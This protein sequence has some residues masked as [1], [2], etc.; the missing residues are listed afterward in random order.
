MEKG[1]ATSYKGI[2]R[3][4]D[5]RLLVRVR[6]IDPRTGKPKDAARILPKG[7][8]PK[9]DG[10]P[11]QDLLLAALSHTGP[12]ASSMRFSEYAEQLVENR[13]DAGTMASP[14]TVWKARY[15]NKEKLFPVWGDFFLT[16][17]KRSDVEA[18]LGTLGKLVR[19]GK[20]TPETV[21]TWWRQFKMIM[22]NAAVTFDIKDPTLK[23]TGV[24]PAL[25]ETYTD[26][27][28]NSL[29]PQEL[30]AFFDA[31][32]N[33]ERE[34][35]AM[36][37]LGTLTGRRPCELR[38]LRRQGPNADIDWQTGVLLIRRSQTLGEALNRTKT[39]KRVRLFLPE[40]LVQVLQT[41]V[42]GLIGKRAESDLLFP[43]RWTRTIETAKGYQTNSVLKK[44]LE[45]IC[46]H[47]GIK[48]HLTPRFMRRTYQDL[49]RAAGVSGLVQKSMSGHATET[50]VEH[51]S[52]V[53]ATEGHEALVKMSAIAGLKEAARL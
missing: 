5:G 31:A 45:R 37:V 39:G 29:L 8:D 6:G 50:M 48:K 28:P 42:A 17:I 23:L 14:A 13:I 34:H 36:L 7:S 38:P 52:T 53:A 27:E 40:M 30:P 51:Y 47:A 43:P 10:I 22:S 9:R 25:H 46:K 21:N 3:L 32:W 24:N 11:T 35:F 16:A 33:H 41:H 20:N 1:T 15:T 44:P 19:V 26:E 12:E 2:S 18:W 49:C 4:P